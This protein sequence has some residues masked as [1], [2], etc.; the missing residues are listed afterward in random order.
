V[1]SN[2]PDAETQPSEARPQPPSPTAALD[3][4]APSRTRENLLDQNTVSAVESSLWFFSS[5]AATGAASRSL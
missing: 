1:S 4:E 5:D 2:Q 3:Q